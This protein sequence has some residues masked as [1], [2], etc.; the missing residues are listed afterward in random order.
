MRAELVRVACRSED[1]F[2]S[3]VRDADAVLTATMK[4]AV[5]ERVIESLGWC[6]HRRMDNVIITGHNAHY[7]EEGQTGL[8]QIPLEEIGLTLQGKF[9]RFAVNSQIRQRWLKKWQSL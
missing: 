3:V 9:P 8:W 6:R 5:N 1:E 4:P 7:S 2:I